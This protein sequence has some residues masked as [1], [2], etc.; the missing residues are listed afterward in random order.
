MHCTIQFHPYK[1]STCLGDSMLVALFH[2][3]EGGTCHWIMVIFPHPLSQVWWSEKFRKLQLLAFSVLLKGG[4]SLVEWFK[5]QLLGWM[6]V[7]TLGREAAVIFH[8]D[9]SVTNYAK[10][11]FQRIV[12]KFSVFSTLITTFRDRWWNK[13]D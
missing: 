2:C 7:A 13:I 5:F 12:K 1:L 10:I 11:W 9:A 6:E 4:V 3:R 8:F